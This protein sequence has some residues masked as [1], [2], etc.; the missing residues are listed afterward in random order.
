MI[1]KTLDDYEYNWTI[2]EKI[3]KGNNRKTSNL[4]KLAKQIILK[5]YP[6]I[7]VYEEIPIKVTKKDTLYLDFYIPSI[8]TAIEVNGKQHDSFSSHFFNSRFDFLKAKA[9]DSKKHSW[10]QINNIT[11]IIFKY[12]DI[13]MWSSLI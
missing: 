13:D 12:N 2:P 3:S 9:N 11:L 4:H 1:V 6:N 8:Q 5:K 7:S 10:C